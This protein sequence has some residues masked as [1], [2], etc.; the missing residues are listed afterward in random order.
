MRKARKKRREG[1]LPIL[2]IKKMDHLLKITQTWK[3]KLFFKKSCIHK[4]KIL[5]EMKKFFEGHKPPE[6]I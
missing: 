4:F 2:G 5:D 3:E 1:V 6:F